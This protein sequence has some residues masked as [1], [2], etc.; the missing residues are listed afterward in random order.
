MSI[1]I[2]EGQTQADGEHA[3]ISLQ[4]LPDSPQ[5]SAQS[6]S[7]SLSLYLSPDLA[8][9]FLSS[10]LA[11]SSAPFLQLTDP[12]VHETCL[13]SPTTTESKEFVLTLMFCTPSELFL[14]TSCILRWCEWEC[15]PQSLVGLERMIVLFYTSKTAAKL[16][17]Q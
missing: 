16:R 10:S 11:Q 3:P 13:L 1:T 14:K 4:M 2:S 12:Q 8:P 9:L 15:C 5:A 6:L 7:L 17:E